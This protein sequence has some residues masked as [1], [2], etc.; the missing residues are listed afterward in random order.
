MSRIATVRPVGHIGQRNVRR[1]VG[2]PRAED[3]GLRA[4]VASTELSSVGE[5]SPAARALTVVSVVRRASRW[6]RLRKG[7]EACAASSALDGAN[8]GSISWGEIEES[9]APLEKLFAPVFFVLTGMQVNL[10]SFLDPALVGLALALTGVA[11]AAKVMSGAVAGPGVD[12]LS[13]GLG[14]VPRGEVGLIFAAGGKSLGVVSDSLF[15]A[16]VIVLMVT[17][18]V[19]PPALKWSLFRSKPASDERIQPRER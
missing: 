11:V 12:R 19:T 1:R 4:W 17:T 18:L 10:A 15:A 9:V 2:P 8:P 6:R 16:L 3:F 5:L 7:E 13:V 14:M